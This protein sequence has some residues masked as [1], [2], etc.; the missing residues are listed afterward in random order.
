MWKMRQ[1][2]GE[3]MHWT[4][5][6]IVIFLLSV[7][8]SAAILAA[9]IRTQSGMVVEGDVQG[10]IVAKGSQTNGDLV[11]VVMK[12]VDIQTIDERGLRGARLARQTVSPIRGIT[13]PPDARL[14]ED[15]ATSDRQIWID[16]TEL[17]SLPVLGELEVGKNGADAR[18]LPRLRVRTGT[19]ERSIAIGELAKIK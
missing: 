9:T 17:I 15:M 10:I 2:M 7:N 4:R 6:A 19:T 13:F 16:S 1:R 8:F 5:S 3:A 14:A 11:F 12:G 18:I